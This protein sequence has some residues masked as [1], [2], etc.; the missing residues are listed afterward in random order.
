MDSLPY[1]SG[2][3]GHFFVQNEGLRRNPNQTVFHVN[4]GVRCLTYSAKANAVITGGLDRVVRLWNPYVNLRPSGT[5]QGHSNPVDH[6]CVQDACDRI[7]S[8]SNDHEL[9]VWDLSDLQC[10]MT[11]SYRRHGITADVT[12]AFFHDRIAALILSGEQQH[13][14]SLRAAGRGSRHTVSH[15]AAVTCAT[16]NDRFSH[17]IT[18]SADGVVKVWE[19]ASGSPAFEFVATET[20]ESDETLAAL[21]DCVIDT[22]KRRLFT[23]QVGWRSCSPS[24][25][26]RRPLTP[27]F[28]LFAVRPC[29][30]RPFPSTSRLTAA[31]VSGTIIMGSF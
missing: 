24:L 11:V 8:Y 15:E 10:L 13:I 25:S 3:S 4:K 6:V 1:A 5:L 14:I 20:K 19:V 21:T 30:F 31:S 27:A 7:F 22:S 23:S 16:F 28:F 2:P 26:R 18:G 17:A 9:R 29:I 12:A